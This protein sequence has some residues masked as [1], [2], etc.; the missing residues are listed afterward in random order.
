MVRT[1]VC[2]NL[3]VFPFFLVNLSELSKHDKAMGATKISRI[4][5]VFGVFVDMG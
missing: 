2:S 3:L 5:T 1:Q 4:L